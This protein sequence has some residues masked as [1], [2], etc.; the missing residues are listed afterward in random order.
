MS[1]EPVTLPGTRQ[2]LIEAR[3]TGET[4]RLYLA[5]P[6]AEPPP[7]GFPVLYM[8]DAN[9]SFATMAQ[10]MAVLS[11]W[12][13]TGVVPM[14]IVGIGYPTED[15]FDGVR[16]GFDYT[17]AGLPDGTP[18]DHAHLLPYPMG[19]AEP[20]Q[21]FIEDEVKPWAQAQAPIDRARQ[22]LLGHSFGGL[23][24]LHALF[25]APGTFTTYI[26]AS[27][28]I[29]WGEPAIHALEARFSADATGRPPLRL[30]A[31]AGEYEQ[32][33]APYE[34]GLPEAEATLA[35]LERFAMID[36]A[37]ALVGRL[38]ALERPW[39]T[40]EFRELADNGHMSLVPS[41]ASLSLRFAS[42]A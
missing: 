36:Q 32:K 16:R 5:L 20:F 14:V 21:R 41:S 7:A 27:P 24:V 17:P 39:L 19:G 23:F 12:S 30:L 8:L 22:A 15:A 35:R 1:P 26:A 25:T 33:L 13:S 9:A 29:T 2:A 37:R 18:Q 34:L 31:T 3:A 28:S 42:A 11:I 10:T 38:N 6:K 40:A 4:Y